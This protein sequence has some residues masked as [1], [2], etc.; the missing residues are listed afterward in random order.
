MLLSAVVAVGLGMYFHGFSFAGGMN[1]TVGGFNTTMVTAAGAQDAI[2]QENIMKLLNRGGIS[3]MM[4]IVN[5]I[6]CAYAFAG[7]VERIGCLQVILESVAHKLDCRWKLIG[8]TLLIGALLTFTTGVASVPIIMIGFLLKDAY[9]DMNLDGVNL[10]RSLE[11][12]GTML[13]PFVPWGA[14]GIY[15]MDLL[16]VTVGQY[17]IWCIPCYLCVVFAMIWAFTGK[18]IK[19]L[20]K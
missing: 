12:A 1:A 3:S 5:T 20:K 10:S 18:G 2:A 7:I 14:S 15:Y 8:A 6:I 16:G 13:L 19:Y 9:R 11:D 4:N 17:A